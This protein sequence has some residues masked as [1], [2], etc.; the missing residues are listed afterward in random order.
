MDS[1]S[2]KPGYQELLDNYKKLEERISRIEL[3]LKLTAPVD[4]INIENEPE[5]EI[6][7]NEESGDLLE[8][9]IG[10]F[11][12]AKIGIVVFIVGIVFLLTFPYHNLPPIIPSLMGYF[13]AVVLVLISLKLTDKFKYIGGYLNGGAISI[14]YFATLRLYFFTH[15]PVITSLSLE[16]IILML[17]FAGSLFISLRNNSMYLTVINLAIGY[18]TSL[19]NNNDYFIFFTAAALTGLTVYLKY[20]YKWN[21][22]LIYAIVLVYFTHLIWF[23]NN[24][25]IGNEIKTL[26]SPL[27]NTVFILIYLILLS[28]SDIIQRSEAQENFQEIFGTTLNIALGYGLFLI[29]TLGIRGLSFT[30][31]H[32]LASAILISFAI[33]YWNKIKSKYSTFLFAMS[34]YL[35]LSVAIINQFPSPDFFIWLCWQSLIVVS[36]AIWFKSKFIIIANFFI[37]LLVFAL[38]VVMEGKLNTVSLSFGIVALLSARILNWKKERLELK[39]DRMRDGYLLSALVIIPYA[40]YH[41]FPREFVSIAW[42]GVALLYYLLSRLLKSKKYR[43]MAIATFLMTIGYI[44]IVAISDLALTYKIISFLFLG[45]VMMVISLLYAKTKTKYFSKD[46]QKT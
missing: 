15:E 8:Y 1:P 22:L 21:S 46:E 42:V 40:L 44:F 32:L 24:P 13:V 16:T 35:A 12:F 38:Y 6:V 34:G 30:L 2:E 31:L 20:R 33:I 18:L 29:V 26:N 10:Q 7:S 23:L 4:Q 25:L 43:W 3:Q 11:W 37:Y 9:R 19:L 41:S 5:T 17:I 28:S 39:T 45:I 27:I 14:F 36:T